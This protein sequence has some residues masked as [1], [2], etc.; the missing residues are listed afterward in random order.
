MTR[1]ALARIL[2][3]RRVEAGLAMLLLVAVPG[4]VHLWLRPA[5]GARFVVPNPAPPNVALP[6]G[7][8]I[9]A[10]SSDAQHNRDTA[11][12]VD[13]LVHDLRFAWAT[14]QDLAP[15]LVIEF[16]APVA[17][18]RLTLHGV[19]APPFVVPTAI[20][21]HCRAPHPSAALGSSLETVGWRVMISIT[22]PC[23]AI[24]VRFKA[25]D[26]ERHSLAATEWVLEPIR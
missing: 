12:L 8:V 1:D 16:P 2:R 14:R 23:T 7:T 5:P 10:S 6:P 3:E 25:K 13:G 24:E 22:E 17:K 20:E 4:L 11:F 21:V 26:L 15:V 19:A 9:T 18:Q